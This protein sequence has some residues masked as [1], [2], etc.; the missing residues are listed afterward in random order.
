MPDDSMLEAV[1]HSQAVLARVPTA[2]GL[3][4][5]V[6][7]DSHLGFGFACVEEGIEI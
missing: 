2:R 7:A 1:C 4:R 6:G 5:N 3:L